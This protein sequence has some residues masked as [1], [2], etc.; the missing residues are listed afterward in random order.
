MG[1]R[2]AFSKHGIAVLGTL[3][4]GVLTLWQG[5]PLARGRAKARYRDGI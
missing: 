2:L 5:A 4:G 1:L 3:L